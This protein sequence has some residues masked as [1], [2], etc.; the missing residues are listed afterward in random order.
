M[1]GLEKLIAN[2]RVTIRRNGK[3]DP[4]GWSANST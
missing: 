3:P 4:E 1:D 2:P